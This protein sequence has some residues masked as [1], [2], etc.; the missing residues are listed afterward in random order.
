MQNQNTHV[1][2]HS[3][4]EMGICCDYCVIQNESIDDDD[5]KYA[6]TQ[7]QNTEKCSIGMSD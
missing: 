1:I 4:L 7:T 3:W 5:T 2:R 6:H